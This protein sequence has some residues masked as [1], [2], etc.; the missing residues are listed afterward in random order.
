MENVSCNCSPRSL[1]DLLWYQKLSSV[2][3]LTFLTST[4]L[5]YH[6]VNCTIDDRAKTL[7]LS[8]M[9]G[10]YLFQNDLHECREEFLVANYVELLFDDP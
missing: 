9:V 7:H 5:R 10:I 1:W 3:S 6:L 2:A 8:L 4:A